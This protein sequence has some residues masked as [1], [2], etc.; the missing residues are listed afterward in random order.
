MSNK[1]TPRSGEAASDALGHQSDANPLPSGRWHQVKASELTR[2]AF[3]KEEPAQEQPRSVSEQAVKEDSAKT[4]TPPVEPPKERPKLQL[5]RRQELEH[6]LKHSPADLDAFLELGRIYRAENRPVDARRVFQ[7]AV[8]IFPDELELRWEYEESI[9]SRS[10]QQLKE[11]TELSQRL[12]TVETDRELKRC[13][14]DWACR[15]M[16]ICRARLARDPSQKAL[17]VALAE[18]MYDG[19]MYEGALDELDPILEDEELSSAAQLIRGRTLIALGKDVEAMASLRA[20]SLRRAFVSPIK[21]RVIALRL[22]CEIAERMGVTLTF[23]RYR[24]NLEQAEQEL[25]KL[26]SSSAS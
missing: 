12:D 9:L 13:Q 6:H 23:E 7:Q 11:V 20:A 10:L 5:E 8:S 16:D 14:D 1:T 17:R 3:T 18:A 19:G 25:A 24:Q 21:T 2:T 22:L 26:T 15:R 4:E